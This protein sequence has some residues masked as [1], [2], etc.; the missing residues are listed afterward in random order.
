M[1]EQVKRIEYVNQMKESYYKKAHRI[2]I[3]YYN[4]FGCNVRSVQYL[5]DGKQ[6]RY[7]E[8]FSSCGLGVSP[9]CTT[10]KLNSEVKKVISKHA[11]TVRV[12]F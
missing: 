8:L 4:D 7:R 6:W 3:D 11:G 5:R 1:K 2:I 10:R 9:V 12:Y